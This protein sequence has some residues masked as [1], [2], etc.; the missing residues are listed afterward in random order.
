M[1]SRIYLFALVTTALLGGV[2]CVSH[3]HAAVAGK[4][5]RNDLTIAR[6]GKT[7]AIIVVSPDAT[8][9]PKGIK[10]GSGNPD[11]FERFAADEL[12]RCIEIMTG[13]RPAVADTPETIGAALKEKHKP[14]LLVGREALKANPG[15]MERL[16]KVAKPDPVLRADA[17]VAERDG[18][19][20][21]LAG[22]TPDG[23]VHAVVEL[24]RRWGCRWYLPTE[25]GECIPEHDTLTVGDLEY[26]YASPFEYRRYG[27]YWNG[28]SDGY[29]P[30][31]LRNRMTRGVPY[32]SPGHSLG[33]YVK[34]LV[35]EGKSGFNV[36]I[37]EDRTATH[38]AA[39]LEDLFRESKPIRLGINDGIYVSD[40][41]TDKQLQ[42]GL[43]DKYFLTPAMT[44]C[45]MTF[46]NKVAALLLAKYPHSK[47][48]ISLIAY[49]NMTLPPQQVLEAAR[50]LV[51][52]LAPIDIDPNHGMDDPRSRPRQE[53]RAMMYRWA[54]VMDGRVVIYDYDQGM[55]VWRDLPNPSHQAF[56]Q[57]VKH[58]AKAGLLGLRTESRGAIAT[59]FLNLHLRGQLMWNPDADVDAMLAEFYPK[60]YGPAAEPMSRYWDA[61]FKAWEDTI[62][63]EHEFFTAPAIYT[64]GL[65]ETLG[66][67]LQAAE[68]L[69]APLAEKAAPSRNEELLLERMRF[70]RLGFEVLSG[71][72]TM[73]FKATRDCDY[74]AAHAIGTKALEARVKLAEMNPT[75]TT[76]AIKG[77]EHR[78]SPA[79]FPGEVKFYGDLQ[80]LTD[81]TEGTLIKK[82][83]FE[84]AFR[85]D[86]NDT[87]LASGWAYREEID[88]SFWEANKD[89][90]SLENRKDY[91]I[92]EWEML[93]T[94]LYA[95]A[96]GVL[97]PDGQSFVG[98]SW[99]RTDVELSGR[100]AAKPVHLYF[101]RLFA[102]AWLYVNGRLVAY[103]PQNP[104]WWRNGYAYQ[105]DVDLSKHVRKGHNLIVVRNHN[106]HHVSGMFSRPFL[107]APKR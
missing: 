68:K 58:Y 69:I 60:F 26:A 82:L 45:F 88:L 80:R 22:L 51:C 93:R 103:R 44:D 81:G 64:P 50:P 23:H 41:E 97:H 39:Q 25:F 2:A 101:P 71:Y 91:P 1:Q 33:K 52:L 96:Q 8:F 66:E 105:W 21:Y 75:F 37:A 61:I 92:T 90:F 102:D 95:Q 10:G 56:R 19:R 83:P 100:E 77:P 49:C 54:E 43:Y 40:S 84:W 55:L 107:Y 13:A 42:A 57:D 27:V 34:E 3:S 29:I 36:P 17:I 98:H 48:T 70:T 76:G 67:N 35:P 87:G 20:I 99:Y 86:P 73:V 4:P 59:V 79:W 104:M 15:L 31:M 62:V 30:F 24:L 85:R 53:F 11:V 89:R 12:A 6:G 38:V 32:A 63:T 47:S 14:I 7:D 106:E 78:G 16:K 74:R 5:G 9:D 94:D 46:Y 72:M 28:S 18:N 65:M